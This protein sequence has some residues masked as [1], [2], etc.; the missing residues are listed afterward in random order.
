MYNTTERIRKQTNNFVYNREK[1]KIIHCT[2][3]LTLKRIT[4]RAKFTSRN[5]KIISGT[6]VVKR[7][8]TKY[9]F[10]NQN[11]ERD[12]SGSLTWY[13]ILAQ[14]YN[15]WRFFMQKSK[16]SQRSHSSVFNNNN[17]IAF[18]FYQIRSIFQKIWSLFTLFFPTPEKLYDRDMRL[19]I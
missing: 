2:N 1:T 9:N 6:I 4:K 8:Q 11:N 15:W 16:Y 12:F 19:L 13:S 17:V 14:N 5:V 18:E 3:I 10:R 7:F